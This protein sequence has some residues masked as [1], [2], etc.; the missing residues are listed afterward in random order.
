MHR[1]D[2]RRSYLNPRCLAT[3]Y[4]AIPSLTARPTY[5][6]VSSGELFIKD[7]CVQNVLERQA[8]SKADN[9]FFRMIIHP[10]AF[11]NS[12]ELVVG[13]LTLSNTGIPVERQVSYYSS[14][15]ASQI[16]LGGMNSADMI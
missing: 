15:Q 16:E 12:T 14:C 11:A 9:Q 4:K 13:L 2:D 8:K 10:F 6:E 3:R 7:P 1:D 5:N